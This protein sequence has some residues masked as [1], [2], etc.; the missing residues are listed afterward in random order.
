MEFALNRP[1]LG[2]SDNSY[3]N[4][5]IMLK[6][7][8]LVGIGGAI[9]SIGRYLASQYIQS[10]FVSSGFPYGTFIVN[11]TGCFLIGLIFAIA[12]KTD[13]QEWRLFLITGVCGGY[14]T[15]SAFS[16][17]SLNLLRSGNIMHFCTYVAGSVILGLIATFIP[18]IVMQKI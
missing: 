3:L 4:L 6:A 16:Y 8:T 11:I 17:E 1:P 12:G 18:I 15:F 5:I 7:F 9:G 2:V 13:I 10:R 14:T